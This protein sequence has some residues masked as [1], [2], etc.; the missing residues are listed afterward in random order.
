LGGFGGGLVGGRGELS[1]VLGGLGGAKW[2]CGRVVNF[3]AHWPDTCRGA[4]V[5]DTIAPPVLCQCCTAPHSSATAAVPALLPT[6]S[7]SPLQVFLVLCVF[8]PGRPP[9]RCRRVICQGGPAGQK[10]T[11]ED[12]IPVLFPAGQKE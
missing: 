1:G 6:V 5:A 10:E 12:R 2:H 11:R 7:P 3:D 9:G 8:L 4:D